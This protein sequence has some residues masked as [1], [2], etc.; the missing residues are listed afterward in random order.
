MTHPRLRDIL[1]IV[2]NILPKLPID[3]AN[4]T[5]TKILRGSTVCHTSHIHR[6]CYGTTMDESVSKLPSS[7][8]LSFCRYDRVH[9]ARSLQSDIK[10]R[11]QVETNKDNIQ[12]DQLQ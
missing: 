11:F 7:F 8:R 9:P 1:A 4:D 2:C 6:A 3:D 12:Q 10:A 5:G